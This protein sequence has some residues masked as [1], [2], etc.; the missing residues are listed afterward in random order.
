MPVSSFGNGYVAITVTETG[1]VTLAVTELSKPFEK[2]FLLSKVRN[3][4]TQK[5]QVILN[6]NMNLLRCI[7]KS[8]PIDAIIAIIDDPP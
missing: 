6:Q 7:L 8:K 2:T 5:W 4:N 1:L 3:E